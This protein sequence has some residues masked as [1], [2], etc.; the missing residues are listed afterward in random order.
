LSRVR[1]FDLSRSD[2]PHN[3]ALCNPFPHFVLSHTPRA[4]CIR[5]P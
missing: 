3:P 1:L 4:S 5:T 2:Y